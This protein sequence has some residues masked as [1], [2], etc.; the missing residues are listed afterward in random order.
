M[1]PAVHGSRVQGARIPLLCTQVDQI[2]AA[3]ST[4]SFLF[5]T[6]TIGGCGWETFR[7][8]LIKQGAAGRTL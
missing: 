5:Y 4:V 2:R 3:N 7:F 8:A 1:D 6:Q